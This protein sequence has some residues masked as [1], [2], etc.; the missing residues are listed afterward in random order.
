AAP[1]HNHFCP[2]FQ[3]VAPPFLAVTCAMATLGT[4]ALLVALAKR[5]QA[6]QWPQSR[7]L[8]AQ[9]ALGTGLFAALLPA[10]AAGIAWG[11]HLGTGLCRLTH[12]LWH[13]SLFAQALLVASG[14]WGTSWARWDPQSRRLA[15]AIWAG[16]LLLATP[17]ALAGG[18]VAGTGCVRRSVGILSPAY[19]LHLA[20]SL[21][22]LLLLP[23]GLLVATLAVP[24]RRASWQAG[25][26]A[27]WVFFGLWAPYGVALAVEFLLHAQLLEPTCGTF[28]S[29][30]H[31][32]GLS[33]G[34]GVLHC[35]LG[36]PVLLLAR[37]C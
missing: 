1:C 20:F 27:S 3:R 30:D 4:A 2:L 13:W 18:T 6:W 37:L 35:G 14:S 11:W 15:V 24:A 5:P 33:E 36:P 21:C 12:L 10:L 22:L 25:G 7:A 17:A 28:E 19:L 23:T 26:G 9:L 31:A 16:A 29:F 8:V 32:L 34:L